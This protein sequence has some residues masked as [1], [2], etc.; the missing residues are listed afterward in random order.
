MHGSL[1]SRVRPA[2]RTKPQGC[3]RKCQSCIFS[4]FLCFN[5]SIGCLAVLRKLAYHIQTSTNQTPLKS[6]TT[7]PYEPLCSKIE[8]YRGRPSIENQDL[9]RSERIDYLRVLLSKL[10][11]ILT[12]AI[13]RDYPIWDGPPHFDDDDLDSFEWGGCFKRWF[14]GIFRSR[15]LWK[16]APHITINDEKHINA[17]TASRSSADK[18]RGLDPSILWSKGE[19]AN[20]LPFIFEQSFLLCPPAGGVGNIEQWLCD[21][22]TLAKQTYIRFNDKVCRISHELFTVHV[23][24]SE[25]RPLSHP[26]CDAH[27]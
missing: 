5:A 1:Q 16:D 23:L 7:F 14:D 24:T 17:F 20:G 21:V 22:I 13:P 12:T 27:H 3:H 9:W 18:A 8:E 26:A 15:H 6:Y 19:V 2:C 4:K 11:S 10:P 25:S